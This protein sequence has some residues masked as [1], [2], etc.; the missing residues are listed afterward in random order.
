MPVDAPAATGYV[1]LTALENLALPPAVG[2]MARQEAKL[3]YLGHVLTENRHGLIIDALVTHATGTAERDAAGAMIADLPDT[4]R[5]TVGG[6]K[7]YDTKGFVH[8][9]RTMGVTPHVGVRSRRPASS[10]S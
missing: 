1:I 10:R 7:N 4:H 5:V 6:D 2:G 8:Q 9:L 3:A